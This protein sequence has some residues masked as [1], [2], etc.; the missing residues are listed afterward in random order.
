MAMSGF[1]IHV[2]RAAGESFVE[3]VRGGRFSLALV[4]SHTDTSEVPGLS[5]AG[6]SPEMMRFTPPADA[7]FLHYGSCMCIDGLPMTPDGRPTPALLTKVALESA[8]IPHIVINA[9]S[10]IAPKL[11]FV[12]TGLPHG[13]NIGAS[14]ALGH[15]D[16]VHAVDFG[17]IVGRTLAALTDCLVIG[18]SLPAGTTTAMAALHGLGYDAVTSSSSRTNPTALKKSVI[19]AAAS[20]L[21][22]KEPFSVIANMGDPMIPFVSGMLSTASSMCRVLLAGGTQMA[23]VLAFAKTLGF[24]SSAVAI[25]TTRYVVDDE[26]ADFLETVGQIDRVPVIAVDP[27]LSESEIP[28]L[29]AF[30]EGHVKE[31]VGAG[32]S[33][34]SAMLRADL[35]TDRLR[36]NIEREYG[37]VFAA[38]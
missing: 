32:G 17:R 3:S 4:I 30:S 20:R 37:R 12:A 9:G 18:E 11:P 38:Q 27:G 26:S 10:R 19:D 16:V 8:S 23:A 6:A 36:Q 13:N 24:H 25:G 2:D 22:D 31:G 28:G 5:V 21:A 7:E 14:P 15:G 34:L 33:M 35:G 29:R 1:D